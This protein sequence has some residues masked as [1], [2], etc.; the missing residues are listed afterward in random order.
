MNKD[1]NMVVTEVLRDISIQTATSVFSPI[2]VDIDKVKSSYGRLLRASS[3]GREGPPVFDGVKADWQDLSK[4]WRQRKGTFPKNK[5]YVGLSDNGESLA[6]SLF[7]MPTEKLFGKT[8]VRTRM[9]QVESDGFYNPR[10]KKQIDT[11][12]RDDR[13]R[14]ARNN[15][16]ARQ[17]VLV[18]IVPFPGVRD[19]D[20]I[21]ALP[22]ADNQKKK[23]WYNNDARPLIGPFTEWFFERKIRTLIMNKIGAMR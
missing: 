23:L 20:Y 10:I 9:V 8:Q 7:A 11:V 4:R 22:I 12:Y 19:G 6:A 13:G 18:Q 3:I 5:F 2:G 15:P 21:N 16:A 17:Q 14:F 1:F